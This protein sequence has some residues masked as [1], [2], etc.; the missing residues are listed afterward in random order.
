MAAEGEQ[1][2]GI[3]KLEQCLRGG[4]SGETS[5]ERPATS[6]SAGTK[7]EEERLMRTRPATTRSFPSMPILLPAQDANKFELSS[8]VVETTFTIL[9]IRFFEHE[10]GRN[11]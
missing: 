4:D 1:A 9:N 11:I 6:A 7:E 8:Q 5:G 10:L 3:C 2:M